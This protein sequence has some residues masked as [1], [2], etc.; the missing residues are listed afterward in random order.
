MRKLPKSRLIPLLLLCAVIIIVLVVVLCC[1]DRGNESV[2]AK[3]KPESPLSADPVREEKPSSDL[4]FLQRIIALP[5]EDAIIA[6]N[7]D[8]TAL[9]QPLEEDSVLNEHVLF[10]QELDWR[11]VRSY[12][13]STKT[14]IYRDGRA[15]NAQ[16][17]WRTWT[18]VQKMM[19]M[20]PLCYLTTDGSIYS[21][22]E[23]VPA[24]DWTGLQDAGLVGGTYIDEATGEYVEWIGYVGLT[25]N[26]RVVS[27][28]LPEK[29]AQELASWKEIRQMTSVYGGILALDGE[30]K[31]R[32]AAADDTAVNPLRE[33]FKGMHARKLME[34]DV[35]LFLLLENGTLAAPEAIYQE[36][37]GVQDV[38]D[39][40]IDGNFDAAMAWTN[41][42]DVV[43][44]RITVESYDE[45]YDYTYTSERLAFVGVT[46]DG[47][48][49]MDGVPQASPAWAKFLT[50]LAQDA[51]VETGALPSY[52][53]EEYAQR[54]EHRSSMVIYPNYAALIGKYDRFFVTG[55]LEDANFTHGDG[56]WHDL[57]SLAGSES[58][59]VGLKSDG[60][61]VAQGLNDTNECEV[62]AWRN[63]TDVAAGY[64]FT[65]GLT[66]YGLVAF[67]GQATTSARVCRTWRD[68]IAIDAC[69]NH[70]IGLRM[71][72]TAY[73]TAA[74]MFEGCTEVLSWSHLIDVAAGEGSRAAGLLLDGTV[75]TTNNVNV[76]NPE[77][78]V[79]L[80][81]IVFGGEVLYGLR[82]D[83]TMVASDPEANA[84]VSAW[85][86][87]VEI[88][89]G[90]AVIGLKKD[91]SLVWY[92]LSEE[93]AEW[94]APELAGW[95]ANTLSDRLEPFFYDYGAVYSLT[96][97]SE[98]VARI[99]PAAVGE[100][101]VVSVDQDCTLSLRGN[102]PETLKNAQI[103][104]AESVW[105]YGRRVLVRFSNGSMKL[106]TDAEES[107]VAASGIAAL[108]G[109]H[110]MK[111]V[112]N[113]MN[114]PN[115]LYVSG[116]DEYGQCGLNNVGGV[117]QIAAGERHSVAVMDNGGF[118]LASGDNA[119][120]QCNVSAWHDVS[121]V[122][123]GAQHT[124]A[125]KT[126]GTLLATGNN[127]QGQCDL[128]AWNG[129]V[130]LIAAGADFSAG[131]T[132]EGTV[133]LAGSISDA[134]GQ[135]RN[136]E[137]IVFIA[138][139]GEGLVGV[140]AT[141]QLYCTSLEARDAG[142][143]RLSG[144]DVP[145]EWLPKMTLSLKFNTF[146]S[147]AYGCVALL[148]SGV[149][150]RNE[151]RYNPNYDDDYGGDFYEVY[152]HGGILPIEDKPVAMVCAVRDGAVLYEDGTVYASDYFPEA[153]QWKNVALITGVRDMLGA[154][155]RDGRV[156]LSGKVNE[157]AAQQLADLEPVKYLEI[158][159]DMIYVVNQEG[160]LISINFLARKTSVMG[161]N[162][163]SVRDGIG[164]RTDG[165]STYKFAEEG[166]KIKDIACGDGGV[167]V[168]YSDGTTSV[169]ISGVE[170]PIVQVEALGDGFIWQQQDGSIFLTG[171]VSDNHRNVADWLIA[172]PRGVKKIVREE[173]AL[174]DP[175]PGTATFKPYSRL[176]IDKSGLYAILP[177]GYVLRKTADK[178]EYD[179]AAR[180][181]VVTEVHQ[182]MMDKEVFRNM[183]QMCSP[184]FGVRKDGTVAVDKSL[185]EYDYAKTMAS[186]RN[187]RALV[188]DGYTALLN[189]GT[190]ITAFPDTKDERIQAA[191]QWT[192]LVDVCYLWNGVVGLRSDGSLVCHN[193]DAKLE[194]KLLKWR[195]IVAIVPYEGN[196]A[197]L[198]TTG[199]VL[200]S[201]A[202]K[203][204][205]PAVDKP[206]SRLYA[207]REEV[208]VLHEDG[209]MGE[210]TF[211]Y[212]GFYGEDNS[213]LV[214]FCT[215]GYCG[216]G[217]KSDGWL[218]YDETNA[219]G[220]S[221]FH[222]NYYEWGID[223]INIDTL[224]GVIVE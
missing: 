29:M 39:Y 72:G 183:A 222:P 92:G 98:L 153:A 203:G 66:E 14:L 160:D 95:N 2:P 7:P 187:V 1:A 149:V 207:H 126:D 84:V 147:G 21:E 73:S 115:Q 82:S 100:D 18:G 112:P 200:L 4:S 131:L 206:A 169:E 93:M 172:L 38:R 24:P 45:L 26:G 208:F 197:G 224:E 108:G 209:T 20:N 132:E 215:D 119:H 37:Y 174:P 102:V 77:E 15:I 212:I 175:V 107:E 210:A 58:H 116:S 185:M 59:V 189:D 109:D 105:A 56:E 154:M 30:G 97:N 9:V 53:P 180:K 145:K 195:N 19:N 17:P 48:L 140:D 192:D 156:L 25:P 44:I 51:H 28:D 194:E 136:W 12:D 182:E 76:S 71:D 113:G 202:V 33:A 90:G 99:A 49:M 101:F 81:D 75:V 123:A 10:L 40:F 110:L 137:K 191:L 41:L 128:S 133:L 3:G 120:G 198:T 142:A 79:N 188:L 179:E 150:V 62:S 223:T 220:M 219:P 60:T 217:L 190:L 83:G 178:Y 64:G 70:V 46:Q 177:N 124:I 88:S 121:Q 31:L 151:I 163:S 135:A 50:R 157:Y 186:W 67:T 86:D 54:A 152:T 170:F 5:D 196:L 68:V 143:V 155:T 221:G 164:L 61:V 111:V 36:I 125:L 158:E 161:H 146:S 35:F 42:A 122:A 89:G 173:E 47:R 165:S 171:Y 141:G 138:A 218:V 91:G 201:D 117:S 159:E 63:I 32:L 130:K 199:E 8:G 94:V 43:L 193:V 144:I 127:N 13:A 204:D 216:V 65:A 167:A 168:L 106:Y 162:V 22:F 85:Q 57:V 211:C 34:E 87:V 52:E 114:Y 214:D 74:D 129:Q 16:Y 205:P 80:K 78:F 176:Y 139:S 104:D 118:L 27:S 23:A 184:K 103:T 96:S 181:W 55:A 6:S 166:K 148:E 213:N 134:L 11:T 69:G